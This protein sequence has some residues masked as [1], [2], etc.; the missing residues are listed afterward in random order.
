MAQLD[1]GHDDPV[2]DIVSRELRA[3]LQDDFPTMGEEHRA[4]RQRKTLVGR[5]FATPEE[6]SAVVA[7][8]ASDRA[9]FV[10][11]QVWPVDGGSLTT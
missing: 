11:G 10:T 7:L 6:I 5:P 2:V 9:S 3:R 4:M 8:L 1:A